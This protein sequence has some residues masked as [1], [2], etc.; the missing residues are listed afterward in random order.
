M[1]TLIEPNHYINVNRPTTLTPSESSIGSTHLEDNTVPVRD[2]LQL[3]ASAAGIADDNAGTSYSVDSLSSPSDYSTPSPPG[4]PISASNRSLIELPA[5]SNMP[6]N[7]NHRSEGDT[8]TKSPRKEGSYL[9]ISSISPQLRHSVTSQWETALTLA[10]AVINSHIIP[11]VQVAINSTYELHNNTIITLLHLAAS[12]EEEL[13][14]SG[15]QEGNGSVH[16]S[17]LDSTL[18]SDPVP[19]G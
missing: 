12:E 2:L 5:V 13:D 4:T 19:P 16:S 7:K 15:I 10:L 3:A 14:M 1:P 18:Q 11:I 17:K 6:K 9:Y 8:P